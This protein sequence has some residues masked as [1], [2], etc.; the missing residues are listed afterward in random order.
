MIVIYGNVVVV[1]LG[2]WHGPHGLSFWTGTVDV[3]LHHR[4]LVTH[5][6]DK[7]IG[8]YSHNDGQ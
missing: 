6:E 8:W 4:S 3:I 2:N 1:A 5:V 7:T